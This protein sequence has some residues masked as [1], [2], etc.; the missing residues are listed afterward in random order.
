V[1]KIPSICAERA[2]ICAENPPLIPI[3]RPLHGTSVSAIKALSDLELLQQ[4]RNGDETA[5][6]E[7]Y[8]RHHDVARRV[9]STYRCGTD[10]DDLVNEAFE[11]VLGALRRGHG[12][13][14]AF[15]AYLFVTMRRLAAE[16]AERPLDEPLD[17]VPDPVIA[18]A[19]ADPLAAEDRQMIVTAFGSLPERWQTVLWH[20]A[21]EGRKPGDLATALGM[22]ANAV[23]ALAYRAREQLRQAYLQAHLR[24]SPRPQCE[25]HR[26]LLGAYVRDGLSRRER[27]ATENHIEHCSACH[28]LVGELNE[29]NQL[30]VRAVVP[31]FLAAPVKGIV[32]AAAATTAAAT[33]AAQVGQT[34]AALSALADVADPTVRRLLS[35]SWLKDAVPAAGGVAAAAVAVVGLTAGTLVLR[36][37]PGAGPDVATETG[38]VAPTAPSTSAATL[39]VAPAAAEGAPPCAV[40]TSTAASSDAPSA[41]SSAASGAGG[42]ADGSESGTGSGTGS[43]SEEPPSIG[44]VLAGLL[45][46]TQAAEADVPDDADTPVPSSGT[47]ARLTDPRCVPHQGGGRQ[48]TVGVANDPVDSVA[49]TVEEAGVGVEAEVLDAVR[50]EVQLE[51]G[52]TTVGLHLPPGCEVDEHDRSVVSCLVGDLLPGTSATATLDLGLDGDGGGATVTV[53]SGDTTLDVQ[54]LDLLPDVQQLP[55]DVQ[56][57][58]DGLLGPP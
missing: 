25:P 32:G 12:P 46:A 8:A 55:D 7:L 15:R 35:W 6:T 16:S 34:G 14:D 26:S 4:V 17:E 9:A 52:A 33:A 18:V 43:D 45:D 20:T 13:T 49:T 27:A 3:F 47:S 53:M 39:P 37:D 22:S 30:L 50:L 57:L 5:F 44:G 51:D 24:V 28:L 36:T 10:A 23:S 29:V 54:A 19:A 40:L 48:L 42:V 38:A 1:R 11:K 21:V 2:A 31:L 58:T 41:T 56:E